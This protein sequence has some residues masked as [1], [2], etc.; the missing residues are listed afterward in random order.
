MGALNFENGEKVVARFSNIGKIN[1]DVFAPGFEI[2]NTVPQSD[3]MKLQG[4]SMAAPMV[5]GVAAMLKSYF[6][7]LTMEEIKKIMLDSAVSYKGKKHQKPGSEDL[8]DF[9]TLSVTGSVINVKN[10]VKLCLKLEKEKM[11]K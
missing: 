4:T 10:A 9:A 3:Y 2:Y 8:V 7:T 5:S 6:P 11:A 1:V